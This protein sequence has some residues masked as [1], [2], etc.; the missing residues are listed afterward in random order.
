MPESMKEGY[1]EEFCGGILKGGI[2]KRREEKGRIKCCKM[3]MFVKGGLPAMAEK[4]PM[5]C[6]GLR[7]K[8]QRREGT[9]RD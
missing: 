1:G 6:W 9:N 8:D 2:A 3:V 4:R 5:Q 7:E